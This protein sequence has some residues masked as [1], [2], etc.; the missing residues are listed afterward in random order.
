MAGAADDAVAAL[1]S[2]VVARSRRIRTALEQLLPVFEQRTG[3]KVT[4]T[5]ASGGQ[6]KQR[7]AEGEVFDVPVIQPPYE[8]VLATG[9]VVAKS[10]TPLATVAVVAAVKAGTPKPDISTGEA[11][12]RALL[13]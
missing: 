9:N 2:L 3:N 5:Y 6:T 11:L 12:K 7:T 4:A 1:I 13:A 8:N 10:E